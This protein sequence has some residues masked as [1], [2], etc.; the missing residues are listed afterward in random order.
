MSQY[1]F[2]SFYEAPTRFWYLLGSLLVFLSILGFVL[3]VLKTGANKPFLTQLKHRVNFFW[4]MAVFV[5]VCFLL[6]KVAMF[7][8]FAFASLFAFREFMTMVPTS[9]GDHYLLAI[10]YYI[11]IPLQYVLVGF[12]VYGVYSVA[13]PLLVLLFV[14]MIASFQSDMH[15][16]M[17]RIAKIQWGVMLTIYCMSYIP[18]LMS[19]HI[20]GYENQ[21]LFLV[22]YLL[23]VSQIGDTLQ[24]VYSRLMFRK[25]IWK[26][27]LGTNKTLEGM[28]F[29]SLLAIMV[30]TGLWW[31]TPFTVFQSFWMSCLII[32]LGVCGHLSMGA[33]KKSVKTKTWGSKTTGYGGALDRLD[34]VIFAAPVFFMIVRWGWGS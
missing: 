24:F 30:G 7:V 27:M 11:F 15:N 4:V 10:C 14:P 33:I 34:S 31:L 1:L 8:L 12:E 2:S 5:V 17:A 3:N 29:G 19:L 6:G 21:M 25:K 28:V 13:L 23:L 32:T 18:A 22:M 9:L 26:F 20:V 16:L